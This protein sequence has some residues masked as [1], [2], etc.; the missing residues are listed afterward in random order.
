MAH[1][2][3]TRQW[4]GLSTAWMLLAGTAPAASPANDN[5]ADRTVLEGDSIAVTARFLDSTIEASVGDPPLP[6]FEPGMLPFTGF[7]SRHFGS[8][9]WEWTAPRSGSVVLTMAPTPDEPML[10]W[11]I[12]AFNMMR[13]S[14]SHPALGLLHPP[15]FHYE[16]T[17]YWATRSW[18]SLPYQ[19]LAYHVIAGQ[20]YFIYGV[21]VLT[22]PAP[23]SFRLQMAGGPVI[24]Q[25]P[26]D[27]QIS[28]GE[29]GLLNV[30]ALGVP[31]PSRIETEH[32]L[33]YAWL[34]HD[35]PI[36][37]ASNSV[38]PL[39]SVSAQ[40]VG[41]YRVV[42]TDAEGSVTSAVARVDVVNQE[43]PPVLEP[44]KRDAGGVGASQPPGWRLS[45]APGRTYVIESSA[46]LVRWGW[47]GVEPMSGLTAELLVTRAGGYPGV[48]APSHVRIRREPFV[49]R[50]GGEL[51]PRVFLRARRATPFD[52]RRWTGLDA[53]QYAKE[54]YGRDVRGQRGVYDVPALLD[55]SRRLPSVLYPEL[56]GVNGVG[57]CLG[58]VMPGTL[59]SLPVWPCLPL[60]DALIDPN[61]YFLANPAGIWDPAR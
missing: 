30:V 4:L 46:D 15:P 40:D 32:P 52:S 39:L 9:W 41:E 42:V 50:L 16:R 43:R 24:L 56:F 7:E 33:L 54:D 1:N 27:V 6:G 28:A 57:D 22:N 20:R 17:R 37:G 8:L 11:S 59:R 48:N 13:S 55:I 23:V 49:F 45:G 60:D 36:P 31:L 3:W 44:V 5:F 29:S 51:R 21:G 47:Q 14:D 18:L 61:Y 19:G 38:L 34:H 2:S 35:E 10:Q 25:N 12:A 26:S 58:Q 53:L